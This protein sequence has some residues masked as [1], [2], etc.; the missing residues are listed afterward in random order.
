MKAAELSVNSTY[1]SEII[2]NL[3]H[4]IHHMA[5]IRIAINELGSIKLPAEFGVA[6]STNRF[7]KV[8]VQ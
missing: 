8:C 3:E 6:A 2:Y 4:T 5:Y 7:R 1:F